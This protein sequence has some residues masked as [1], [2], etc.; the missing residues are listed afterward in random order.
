MATHRAKN[1]TVIVNN[2]LTMG[3]KLS[4]FT[5][6]IFITHEFYILLHENILTQTGY[7]CHQVSLVK[8]V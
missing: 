3:S 6:L 5:V 1:V 2:N 8:T 7:H 4:L